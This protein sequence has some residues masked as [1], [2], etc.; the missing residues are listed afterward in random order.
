MVAVD[1]VA[2]D[3]VKRPI[4]IHEPFALLQF[5]FLAPVRYNVD[6]IK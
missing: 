1:M 4:L 2:A 6:C 3:T 5:S